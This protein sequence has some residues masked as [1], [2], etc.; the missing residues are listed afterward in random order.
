MEQDVFFTAAHNVRQYRFKHV[1]DVTH[2]AVTEPCVI[3]LTILIT[4]Y[5]QKRQGFGQFINKRSSRETDRTLGCCSY[6]YQGFSP[7]G[8]LLA[9]TLLHE[10]YLVNAETVELFTC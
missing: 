8:L 3:K 5:L 7:I 2:T 1:S 10:M 4:Q 6:L 9:P